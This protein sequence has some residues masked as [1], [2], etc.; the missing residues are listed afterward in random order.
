MATDNEK[1][2]ENEGGE[3]G[4]IG[5]EILYTCFVMY[6]FNL[7]S[8]VRVKVVQQSHSEWIGKC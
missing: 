3:I 4:L 1:A 5:L 8:E 2:E 6:V 7:R